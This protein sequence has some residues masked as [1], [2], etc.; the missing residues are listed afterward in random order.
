MENSINFFWNRPLMLFKKTKSMNSRKSYLENYQIIEQAELSCAKLRLGYDR[1]R[2]IRPEPEPDVDFKILVP[3][4]KNRIQHVK[5]L[6][7]F[8]HPSF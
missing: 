6:S 2:I 5:I 8:F 7:I 4:W 3:V 1:N